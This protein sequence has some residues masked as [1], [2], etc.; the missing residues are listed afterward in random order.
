[1]SKTHAAWSAIRGP[2]MT[3]EIKRN[4]ET[5]GLVC[6]DLFTKQLTKKMINSKRQPLNYR[7]R[8][9]QNVAGLNWFHDAKLYP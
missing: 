2:V 6:H 4:E 7:D 9:I 1:M 5:N 3:N 8:Q